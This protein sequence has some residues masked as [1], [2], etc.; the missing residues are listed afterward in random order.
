M[1]DS[2]RGLSGA[3]V[4]GDAEEETGQCQRGEAQAEL[5]L[6]GEGRA[7]L[8]HLPVSGGYFICMPQLPTQKNDVLFEVSLF[9]MQ[10]H[11]SKFLTICFRITEPL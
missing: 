8:W 11:I 1:E 3:S 2:N 7:V 9:K 10:L 4:T 6:P 5:V